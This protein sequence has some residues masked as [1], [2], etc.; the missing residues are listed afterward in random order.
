MSKQV[1]FPTLGSWPLIGS[2]AFS[3]GFAPVVV[4]K[5]PLKKSG[6]FAVQKD[7]TKE[8]LSVLEIFKRSAGEHSGDIFLRTSYG[9]FFLEERDF[10][11]PQL[12]ES[13]YSGGSQGKAAKQETIIIPPHPISLHGYAWDYDLHIPVVFW[14]PAGV[15]I[16]KG[17]YNGLAIQQDIAPTLASILGVPAPAMA[18]GRV[19][20]EALKNGGK[21]GRVPIKRPRAIVI[22]VQDQ[23]GMDYLKV[24]AGRAPFYEKLMREGANFV[25]GSVSHVDVETSVGHAAIGSG[26]FPPQHLIN[27]NRQFH[28]G[29]W[30]SVPAFSLPTPAGPMRDGYPG[31]FMTPTLSDEWLK[32]RGGRPKVFALA[33]AARAAIALG[34]HGSMFKGNGK[35]VVTWVEEGP[36]GQGRFTTDKEVFELPVALRDAVPTKVIEDFVKEVGGKWQGH[37]LLDAAGKPDLYMASASP[38]SPRFESFLVVAAID[39]MAIGQ[40][41]ETDLVWVNMKAT[42]YCGHAFGFESD[43][44]G[45]VLEAADSGAARIVDAVSQASGGDYVVVFTADHGCAPL[46]ELSGAVRFPRQKLLAAINERFDHTANNLDVALYLTSSQLYLNRQELAFNGHKIGEVVAFLKAFE[47]PLAKPYNVLADQWLK[48][49]K[50][51]M[52]RLFEDVVSREELIG[53]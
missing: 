27:A 26:A 36:S 8:R 46:P 38:T 25:N 39:E 34:G 37:D 1:K 30:T 17:Q 22:F 51:P 9:S 41:D 29:T 45:D 32:S 4:A 19:L 24:H 11:G 10:T 50:K 16:R 44:C 43:E 14:D 21:Q 12:R 33:S 48:K 2:L 23:V 31:F 35:S 28:T 13:R 18:R 20:G 42:D 52:Q 40:D 3:L 49:G 5:E 53:H 6:K 7:K 47:A 15:Y